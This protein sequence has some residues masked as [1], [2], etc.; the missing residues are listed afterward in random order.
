MAARPTL[1]AAMIVRDEERFLDGC[2]ASLV[3]FVDEIVVVDTGST[4][5]T[6]EIARRHG[7]RLASFEWQGDFAAARNVALDLARGDWI[8]YIDADE[9]LSGDRAALDAQLADPQLVALTVRFRPVSGYTLYREHRLFRRHPQVRFR[10]VIHESHL[11]ALNELAAATGGRIEESAVLIDHL[12]YDG[13]QSHKHPRNL[14]LLEARLALDPGHV[15]SWWHLGATLDGLGR[16][17]E[18]VAAWQRGIDVVRG[19]GISVAFDA[20]PFLALLAWRADRGLE[21][22]PLLSEARARFPGMPE[23]EWFRARALMA[24]QR[25]EQ[26][27]AVL[28]PLAAIDADELVGALAHSQRLFRVLAPEAAGL[29]AFRLGRYAEAAQWYATAELAEPTVERSTKRR[30]M[31]AL[32]R[33]AP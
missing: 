6:P 17:D 32:A 26:A 8:L 11:P 12:G 31:E 13:D 5:R 20:Q 7:A 16:G 27:L 19:R 24:T 28:S 2:L 18:A 22:E 9:R 10:G 15:Y 33:R 4:D 23:V 25:F 21:N 29:C 14:P 30:W 3:G 1:S